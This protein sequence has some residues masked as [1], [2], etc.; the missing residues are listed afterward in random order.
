[1]IVIN[2][3]SL[4]FGV[5][6]NLTILLMAEEG[7][8]Y[9]AFLA[10]H[11][12]QL[13]AAT[14]IGGGCASVFLIALVVSAILELRLPYLAFTEAFYYAIMSAA[15]YFITSI[16]LIYTAH[17]LWR[18]RRFKENISQVQFIHGHHRLM[19]LTVLFMAYIL[20]G[21][22]AFSHIE[23]WRYLDAVYWA[24][25]TILTIGFG[26]FKPSTNLG[27]ALLIP[28]ATCGVFI[29]FL[30][31]YCIPKLIFGKGESMWEIYL[32]DQGRLKKVQQREEREQTKKATYSHPLS[33]K[34]TDE[35]KSCVLRVDTV[36]GNEASECQSKQVKEKEEL[37]ARRRDFDLMHD[38]LQ[39]SAR[40]RLWYSVALSGL[41]LLLLWLVGAACFF[42]FERTHG[43]TYFD[44]VY[45]ASIS[46]L[47]IG[48]GDSTLSSNPGKAFFVMW[49]LIVVPTLTML[50][51]SAVEAVG[52][53]Y[54]VAKKAWLIT[55]KDW[56][57]RRYLGK[58]PPKQ[59]ENLYGE[60]PSSQAWAFLSL[61][62]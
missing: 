51:S 20:T 4:F 25:V 36:H 47:V 26:D 45:F 21:A 19:L 43:W 37:E 29:L 13:I 33:A 27:R 58:I 2:A 14:I 12:L 50:I 11:N 62:D 46:I 32:R 24:D 6:A 44:A 16:F 38:L 35:E 39:T 56:F 10:K 40:K 41:C 53:P 57:N 61:T 49:S 30:V 60:L 34:P 1:L 59:K 5:V 48:Y 54:L 52:H 7:N 42:S 17:T 23:G 31:V 15:L 55:L 3:L 22:A 9:L 18:S 8:G 28:Y